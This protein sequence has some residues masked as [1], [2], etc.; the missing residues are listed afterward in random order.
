MGYAKGDQNPHL[1]LAAHALGD[2]RDLGL[3]DDHAI[4]AFGTPNLTARSRHSSGV[5]LVPFLK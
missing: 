3:G 4:G 2:V 5:G 1:R